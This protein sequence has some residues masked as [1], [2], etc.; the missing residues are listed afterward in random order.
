VLWV[1]VGVFGQM[2]NRLREQWRARME[3]ANEPTAAVI[4]VQS[5]RSSSR[6]SESGF[7]ADKK[8]KAPYSVSKARLSPAAIRPT[9]HAS[10]SG[11]WSKAPVPSAGLFDTSAPLLAVC[12]PGHQK[13]QC[14]GGFQR[15]FVQDPFGVDPLHWFVIA[16]AM[17]SPC[18]IIYDCGPARRL[19]G[20]SRPVP[21]CMHVRFC[22]FPSF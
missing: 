15:L 9:R 5:N 4:N 19:Q 14:S 12:T 3:R 16:S 6:G 18:H 17:Q 20:R 8:D 11:V 10:S 13:V 22:D 1:A 7:D 21:N 2:Q